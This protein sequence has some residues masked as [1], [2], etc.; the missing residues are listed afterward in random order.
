MVVVKAFMIKHLPYH[1]QQLQKKNGNKD[2]KTRG[3]YKELKYHYPHKLWKYTKFHG[4]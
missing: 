1:L 2:I 4:Y 3:K